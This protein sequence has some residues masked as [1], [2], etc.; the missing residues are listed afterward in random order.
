MFNHYKPM[1]TACPTC[2]MDR[3]A[4]V[5]GLWCS[6]LQPVLALRVGHGTVVLV[7]VVHFWGPLQHH[8][9]FSIRGLILPWIYI[10]TYYIYKINYKRYYK[11]FFARCR[12]LTWPYPMLRHINWPSTFR[13]GTGSR[14]FAEMTATP[15]LSKEAE[16]ALGSI[17]ARSSGRKLLMF[18]A[19]DIN[20]PTDQTWWNMMKLC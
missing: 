3:V 10:Y 18:G 13:G 5:P 1:E 12:F 2:V 7:I 4:A 17:K 15:R 19:T 20:R 16:S 11:M 14:Y 8:L 6:E 9:R